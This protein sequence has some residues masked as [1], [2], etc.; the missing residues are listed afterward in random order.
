M[1]MRLPVSL[2]VEFRGVKPERDFVI[3]ETG[4]RRTAAPVL[5]FEAEKPDGD[6][7]IIEV[8]GSSLDRIVP[9]VDYA[10]FRKGDRF[11]LTGVAV[12][13]DRGSEWGSYFAVEGIRPEV[14]PIA[15]KAVSAT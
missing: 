3:R 7:E 4:E 14:T 9:P 10:K 15:P 6:V 11:T 5:K 8:S 1:S 12:I 13:Q 2:E